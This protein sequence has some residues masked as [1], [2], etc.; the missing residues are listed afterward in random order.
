MATEDPSIN[1]DDDLFNFDGLSRS[2]SEIA[3]SATAATATAAKSAHATAPKVPAPALP[4]PVATKATSERSTAAL[5]AAAAPAAP[6]VLTSTTP[7][8]LPLVKPVVAKAVEPR[9]AA[10]AAPLAPVRA[11]GKRPAALTFGLLGI[12][13]LL[14]IA[15]VGVVWHS[16]SGAD[17]QKNPEAL[18]VVHQSVPAP[19]AVVTKPP[20]FQ[21][22][23]IHVPQPSEGELALA[24]A[25][26]EIKRG[27]YERARARMYSLLSVIDRF[28]I[29]ER[30]NLAARA[31]VLAADAYREQADAVERQTIS[32]HEAPGFVSELAGKHP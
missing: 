25:T 23:D 21:N 6:A 1:E 15:L 20:A 13:M 3:T 16:M 27:E 22:L 8:Q 29:A 26:D 32:V 19:I 31:Q 24:A 7:G 2:T 11:S 12:A 10:P 18:P 17:A 28:K 4:T 30:P 9:S 14:N 5:P